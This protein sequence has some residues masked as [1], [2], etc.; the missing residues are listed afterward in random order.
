M[1]KLG[2]AKTASPTLNLETSAPT[3]SISPES[4][5]PRIGCR[6]PSIPNTSGAIGPKPRGIESDLA[7]QSPDD[8]VAAWILIST[9]LRFG[10]GFAMSS[11]PTTSGGPYLL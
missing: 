7:L 10:A 8:T 9:S 2:N 3:A 11:M 4:S 5:V 6:G 1:A